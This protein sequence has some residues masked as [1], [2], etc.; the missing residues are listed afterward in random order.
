MNVVEN[1]LYFRGRRPPCQRLRLKA[2]PQSAKEPSPRASIPTATLRRAHCSHVFQG[3]CREAG[4][5]PVRLVLGGSERQP[6]VPAISQGGAS[7]PTRRQDASALADSY[8][9][10]SRIATRA[11]MRTSANASCAICKRN[12]LCQ[13]LRSIYLSLCI[14]IYPFRCVSINSPAGGARAQLRGRAAV[15]AA[16]LSEKPNNKLPRGGLPGCV[17]AE[18]SAFQRINGEEPLALAGKRRDVVPR[19]TGP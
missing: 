10:S 12:S 8:S 18:A 19:D 7:H 15:F 11:A 9:K 4:E 3:F 1:G 5:S 16:S 6:D 17:C 2:K 13:K 14:T